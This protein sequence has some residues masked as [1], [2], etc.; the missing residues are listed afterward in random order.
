V[1]KAPAFSADNQRIITQKR[2]GVG[3]V[4][5]LLTSRSRLRRKRKASE[6]EGNEQ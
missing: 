1:L 2:V 3:E 5:A 4:A 6:H